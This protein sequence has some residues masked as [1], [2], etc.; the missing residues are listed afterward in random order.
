M[1]LYELTDDQAALLRDI[2]AGVSLGGAALDREDEGALLAAL[3]SPGTHLVAVDDPTTGSTR[4]LGPMSAAEAEACADR[5]H[6]SPVR[7]HSALV[8]VAEPE[9][10]GALLAAW[11]M[12]A[13]PCM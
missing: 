3:S 12:A 4:L 2:V 13:G 9:D 10:E 11:G 1:A 8:D 6:L 5:L 7:P